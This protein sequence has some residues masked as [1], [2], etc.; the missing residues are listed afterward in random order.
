MGLWE[1]LKFLIETGHVCGIEF[2]Y[3]SVLRMNRWPRHVYL[4]TDQPV[5]QMYDIF[6]PPPHFMYVPSS[7]NVFL[8][9]AGQWLDTE[10]R[11]L[12]TAKTISPFSPES[13]T[14]CWMDMTTDYVPGWEV[15]NTE[16]QTATDRTLSDCSLPHCS[17]SGDKN[18]NE[19]M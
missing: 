19:C 17:G 8:L 1:K 11:C 13:S 4:N 9:P 5:V 14:G 12:M 2:M 18:N 15:N 6:N 7:D 10:S 3:E 16:S